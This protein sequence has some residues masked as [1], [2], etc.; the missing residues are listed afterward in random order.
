MDENSYYQQ[1]KYRQGA[2][3]VSCL[4][5]VVMLGFIYGLFCFVCGALSSKVINAEID[6]KENDVDVAEDLV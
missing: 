6:N 4:I 3:L 2:E 1:Y 5:A